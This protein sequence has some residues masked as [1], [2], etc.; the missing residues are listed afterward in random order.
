MAKSIGN[1]YCLVFLP[2][3][4]QSFILEITL[5]YILQYYTGS[6]HIVRNSGRKFWL[7]FGSALAFEWSL[8]SHEAIYCSNPFEFFTSHRPKRDLSK[9]LWRDSGSDDLNEDG[10]TGEKEYCEIVDACVDDCDLFQ[11]KD[12]STPFVIV[13]KEGL[14]SLK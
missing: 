1:C 3:I 8:K 10:C 9:S 13:C 6:P 12:D 7:N 4:A 2:S 11:T 5:A 14:V